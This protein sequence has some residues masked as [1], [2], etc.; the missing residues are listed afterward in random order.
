MNKRAG[1]IARTFTVIMYK[2]RGMRCNAGHYAADAR[3]K[4]RI[5]YSC[6]DLSVRYS[7]PVNEGGQLSWRAVCLAH[8]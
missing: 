3:A 7:W 1:D 8:I 2:E 5:V 6:L 4:D